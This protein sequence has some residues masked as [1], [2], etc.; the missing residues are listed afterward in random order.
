MMRLLEEGESITGIGRIYG[1]SRDRVRTQMKRFGLSKS[2]PFSKYSKEQV[3]TWSDRVI[4]GETFKA[5][6]QELSVDT[7]LIRKYLIHYGHDV[8]EIKRQRSLHRYDGM[9]YSSWT[10]LPG[11]HRV[12]NNNTV[13]D[14]QCVCGEVRTVSLTNLMGGATKS[15]GCVGF[16][17]RQ[18]YP[19]VCTQTGQTIVSTKA[20]SQMLGAN[21]MTISRAFNRNGRYVDKSGNEWIMQTDK[22]VPFQRTKSNNII[23]LCKERKEQV[24][25]CKALAELIDAPVDTIKWYSQE[26]R[27]YT[28][29]SGEVWIPI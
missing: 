15:C 16:V 9:I 24:V 18:S 8:E 17:D 27:P 28:S 3:Q 29:K 6:A 2:S 10:V 26:R 23:W 13:L 5:I 20:L 21:Y 22:P 12:Q 25:T 19:W 7:D 1:V 4:K 14:C 11:T